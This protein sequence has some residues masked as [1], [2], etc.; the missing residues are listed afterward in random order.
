MSQL[1]AK[2][3]LLQQ[4]TPEQLHTAKKVDQNVKKTILKT[5]RLKKVSR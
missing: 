4:Q 5:P 3:V 2:S 1:K